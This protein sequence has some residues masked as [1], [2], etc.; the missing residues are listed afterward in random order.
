MDASPLLLKQRSG[1][2]QPGAAFKRLE[3]NED[4]LWI[5]SYTDRKIKA[6][7]CCC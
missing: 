7:I 1:S 4:D 2:L 3:E 6:I 5:P